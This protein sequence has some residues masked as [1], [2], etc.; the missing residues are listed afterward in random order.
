MPLSANEQHIILSILLMAGLHGLML[1]WMGC[2]RVP[3]LFLFPVKNPKSQKQ[4]LDSLPRWARWPADNYNNISEAPTSFYAVAIA[5]I[6]LGRAD[7]WDAVLCLSYVGLRFVHSVFQATINFIPVR[8]GLFALSWG[9][10]IALTVRHLISL[11]G[12]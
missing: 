9:V 7:Y 6:L 4:V 1:I 8:F 10:L 12:L 3:A 2:T 11:L 5:I